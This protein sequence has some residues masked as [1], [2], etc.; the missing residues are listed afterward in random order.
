MKVLGKRILLIKPETKKSSIELTDFEKA[1]IERELMAKWTHLT[2]H[3]V[4]DDV[5]KVKAGDT[6]YVYANS[7]ANAEIVE[8]NETKML[9]ISEAEVAINW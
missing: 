8:I 6:V 5:T 3:A 1:Q 2:V 9:I 7:L 4:G